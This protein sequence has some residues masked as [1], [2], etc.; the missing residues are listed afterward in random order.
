MNTGPEI[1]G[2]RRRI[3]VQVAAAEAGSRGAAP[4]GEERRWVANNGVVEVVITTSAEGLLR[5]IRRIK[6][7]SEE[8][9]RLRIILGSQYYQEMKRQNG[10][11]ELNRFIECMQQ[12]KHEV[13]LP[14]NTE[15]G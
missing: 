15:R 3:A 11:E 12:R 2:G 8:L 14:S 5:Y 9:P 7:A 10:G 6:A 4:Q 1:A 13:V